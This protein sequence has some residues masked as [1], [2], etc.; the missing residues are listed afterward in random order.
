MKPHV[1]FSTPRLLIR[2]WTYDDIEPFLA[3]YGDLQVMAPL[4]APPLQSMEEAR[5]RMA[6]RFE[7]GKNDPPGLGFWAIERK[8]DGQVVGSVILKPLPEDTRV[9]VGWHLG[10]A[11]WG[12]GYASEAGAGALKYGFEERG[13]DEVFAIVREEN[14][15]S[16]AVCGRIGLKFLEMTHRYHGLELRL[17]TLNLADWHAQCGRILSGAPA[18]R[19]CPHAPSSSDN[20]RRPRRER[21]PARHSGGSRRRVLAD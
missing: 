18:L 19:S 4:L 2:P 7:A 1:I 16:Q 21:G 9:E 5:Q 15:K 11:F 20:Q 14:V 6:K 17:Y 10:R 12:Q 8:D 3:I 13:L